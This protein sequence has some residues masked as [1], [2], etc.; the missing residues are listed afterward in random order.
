MN[1]IR[2]FIICFCLIVS[3]LF[4]FCKS[5]KKAE[6][7]NIFAAASLK[8][9]L[10]KTAEV[11]KKKTGIELSLNFASSGILARQIEQGA[12]VDFF[13]SA[14]L[15]WID[16]ISEKKLLLA[17]SKLELAQNKMALIVPEGNKLSDLKHLKPEQMTSLFN[18]RLA[19]GDPNHVPAGKYAKEILEHHKLWQI[20][21]SRILPC[22]NAR[23]TLLMVEMGEVEL[24]IVYLSDTKK[25]KKIRCIYEFEESDSSPILYY[26]AHR[27]KPNSKVQDFQNFLKQPESKRIW[28]DYAFIVHD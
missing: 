17:S 16:Y 7:L 24:G 11:Y 10:S 20:L 6:S 28:K 2:I 5:E 4:T 25:S 1:P 27:T 14:N 3:Q 15:D 21:K 23:E 18:G 9:V 8:D 13:F 19:I 12:E 22:K 26:S